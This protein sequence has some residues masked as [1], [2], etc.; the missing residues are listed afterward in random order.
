MSA[1][2]GHEDDDTTR[3]YL[4]RGNDEPTGDEV[5]ED[6]LEFVGVFDELDE[7]VQGDANA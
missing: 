7:P 4:K 6:V 2:A 5:W 3:K 1:C